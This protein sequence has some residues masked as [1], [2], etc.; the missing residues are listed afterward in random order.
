M[1]QQVISANRLSDGLV[2]YLASDD[3]W[4]EWI[5]R[6]E[7]ATDEAAADGLLARAKLAEE[8]RI[9]LDPYLVQV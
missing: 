6:G 8:N 5:S 9:V 2:V 3:S 7:I 1:T 4:S